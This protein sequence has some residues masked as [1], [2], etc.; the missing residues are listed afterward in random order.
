RRRPGAGGLWRR[1]V[2]PSLPRRR[3][4]RCAR[5]CPG[6]ACH[7]RDGWS[8]DY[9]PAQGA[10]RLHCFRRLTATKSAHLMHAGA[11]ENARAPSA[12]GD[13]LP[14]LV[15]RQKRERERHGAVWSF[16]EERCMMGQLDNRVAIITGAG[17]GIGKAIALAYAREGAK[18][19]LAARTRA[20]L[21]QTVQ[22]VEAC[23][24]ETCLIAMDV[25]EAAQAEQMVRMSM[26]RFATIDI[27]VNNAGVA[28][29]IAPLQESDIAEWVRTLQ[30]NVVGPYLCCRAV[31][32]TML[33]HQRG[34]IINVA[35]A[36]ATNAWRN[37]S[38]YV[39]SKAA[40]VRLTET[41]ALELEGTNI[42]VNAL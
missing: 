21:A 32:P 6:G 35:G 31:L 5:W 28:G 11:N 41:L 7:P 42:Q 18:L 36:G 15:T 37:I 17:R 40:V 24:A 20:Q 25:T 22:E 1:L 33:Q 26:E 10:R 39:V 12:P 38:A 30:V 27:L 34:K 23:G 9:D 2:P 4:T 14:V 13:V 29:P 19:V 3:K 16:C 8:S